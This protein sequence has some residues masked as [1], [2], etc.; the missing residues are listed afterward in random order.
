MSWETEFEEMMPDEVTRQ[1][2]TGVNDHGEMQHGSAMKV[3]CRIAYKPQLVARSIAEVTGAIQEVI[4]TCQIYSIG[5]Q[6]WLWNPRDKVTLPDGTSPEI[7]SVD[8]NSDS[9][10]VHH[11]KV[12][13]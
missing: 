2:Y 7:L 1:P 9:D 5:N 11:Q 6:T 3:Q 4:S 12:Y 10:G 13:C 8:T